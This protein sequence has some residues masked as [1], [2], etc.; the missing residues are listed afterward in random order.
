MTTRRNALQEW[1]GCPELLQSERDPERR[2]IF[3]RGTCAHFTPILTRVPRLLVV[4]QF[5]FFSIFKPFTERHL[6]GRKRVPRFRVPI[7]ARFWRE[8]ADQRASSLRDLVFT[9]QTPA[10]TKG[11]STL[12]GRSAHLRARTARK[13]GPDGAPSLTGSRDDDL[14]D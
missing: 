9:C 12:F 2:A 13:W 14:F 3:A 1:Q 10:K 11:P 7:R 4:V 5:E 8:W 6:E